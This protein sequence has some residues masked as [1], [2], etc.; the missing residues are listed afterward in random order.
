MK[1][2]LIITS[3]VLFLTI[4]AVNSIPQLQLASA[5]LISLAASHDR[6]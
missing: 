5:T 6:G 2:F 1:A 4:N 3:F